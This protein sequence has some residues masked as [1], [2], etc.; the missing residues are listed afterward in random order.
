MVEEPR[1]RCKSCHAKSHLAGN[2]C[3]PESMEE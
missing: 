1:F 2:L 3:E